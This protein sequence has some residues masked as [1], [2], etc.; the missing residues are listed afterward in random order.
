MVRQP[1]VLTSAAPADGDRRMERYGRDPV[2][3]GSGRRAPAGR[4][5]GTGDGH[6]GRRHSI[7]CDGG[8]Y[9]PGE[10]RPSPGRLERSVT[11]I[12]VIAPLKRLA[13]VLLFSACLRGQDDIPDTRLYPRPLHQPGRHS[14][15]AGD[16]PRPG[17][18]VRRSSFETVLHISSR[19][20]EA[21]VSDG[22]GRDLEILAVLAP[23]G[24]PIQNPVQRGESDL[25]QPEH[26]DRPRPRHQWPGTGARYG[27]AGPGPGSCNS[28]ERSTRARD[29][30]SSTPRACSEAKLWWTAPTVHY[31]CH[32][33]TYDGPP[34]AGR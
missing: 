8:G 17:D 6:G 4:L 16:P 29:P 28:R 24:R 21:A 15:P 25:G 2:A 5:H 18:P 27:R 9:H 12:E 7:R 31:S 14:R 1:D 26:P 11:L 20:S 32:R 33:W 3:R 13:L 23:H 30:W 19:C 10:V 34:A 22:R